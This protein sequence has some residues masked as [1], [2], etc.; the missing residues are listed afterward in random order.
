MESF[1]NKIYNISIDRFLFNIPLLD[2]FAVQEDGITV[3]PQESFFDQ[4]EEIF[5]NQHLSFFQV[6]QTIPNLTEVKNKGSFHKHDFYEMIY[7]YQ[8]KVTNYIDSCQ[9]V[10]ELNLK[11]GDLCLLTPNAAH[12]L[13]VEGDSNIIFNILMKKTLFQRLAQEILSHDNPF[14][15]FLI[16][17]LFEKN[18]EESYLLFSK[19]LCNT[20]DQSVLQLI[21]EYAETGNQYFLKLN[22]YLMILFSDL[23][24]AYQNYLDEN[25]I[26]QVCHPKISEILSYIIE[27]CSIATLEKTAEQFHYNPQYL[28]RL[29][30]QY[31]NQSFSN[32]RR[33][34]C[35]ERATYLLIHTDR[36][37]QEIIDRSGFE[38]AY[39]FRIFHEKYHISPLEY[40]KRFTVL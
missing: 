26:Q 9:T 3:L 39:F 24:T 18:Q 6:K 37:I 34:I 30:K 22:G 16:N 25:S 15:H 19:H 31:T 27:N 5:I 11:Q 10:K 7:V 4:D 21:K 8:G 32:F 28:S 12:Q 14:N 1:I 40:R 29:L 35:M 33:Q 13:Q 23:L 17:S 20:I 2:Y 36:P 38:T